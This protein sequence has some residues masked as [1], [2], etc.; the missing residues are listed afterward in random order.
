[1]WIHDFCGKWQS[2]RTLMWSRCCSR[3]GRQIH[4]LPAKIADQRSSDHYQ[5]SRQH[6]H[7]QW[8]SFWSDLKDAADPKGAC[9]RPACGASEIFKDLHFFSIIHSQS[10]WKS[11]STIFTIINQ[12]C[13]ENSERALTPSSPSLSPLGRALRTCIARSVPAC[14]RRLAHRVGKLS[15]KMQDDI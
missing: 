1:M 14:R 5:S 13:T 11:T 12:K 10:F 7:Q 8:V 3:R 9:A 15:K 4:R 6:Y 2:R